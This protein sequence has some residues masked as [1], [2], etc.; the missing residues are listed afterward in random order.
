M[1]IC[2]TIKVPVACYQPSTCLAIFALAG[3]FTITM[4]GAPFLNIF[5]LNEE[6]Q[7]WWLD[8]SEMKK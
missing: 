2:Y 5:V 4:K 3:F 8:D 6:V 7:S 1:L